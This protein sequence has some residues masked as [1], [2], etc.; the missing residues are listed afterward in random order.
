[1]HAMPRYRT[2]RRIGIGV[3]PHDPAA[4]SLSLSLP[5]Q[6]QLAPL[7]I[8]LANRKLNR[9]DCSPAGD[10]CAQ[11]AIT[12]GKNRCFSDLCQ[13]CRPTQFAIGLGYYGR[14]D[15]VA[16]L[17][18]ALSLGAETCALDP[19]F[20]PPPQAIWP[21]PKSRP[22]PHAQVHS[23]KVQAVPSSHSC[24]RAWIG[25]VLV[26]QGMRGECNLRR[27][28]TRGQLDVRWVQHV[29]KVVCH[30]GRV[31]RRWTSVWLFEPDDEWDTTTGHYFS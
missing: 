4:I 10:N 17:L 6:I 16:V 23:P 1:M 19:S 3:M 25:I 9:Y 29:A 22:K 28:R 30:Q 21:V 13:K 11:P 27:F 7:V 18:D 31:M 20:L 24:K 15:P 8:T 26:K 2:R 5:Q 14:Q 12:I